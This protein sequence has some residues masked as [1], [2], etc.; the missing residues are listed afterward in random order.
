MKKHEKIKV[1]AQEKIDDA[2]P[3]PDELADAIIDDLLATVKTNGRIINR[4]ILKDSILHGFTKLELATVADDDDTEA[5]EQGAPVDP[6]VAREDILNAISNSIFESFEILNIP[7][8]PLAAT[9]ATNAALAAAET[10][11]KYFIR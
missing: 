3:T 6:V 5:N 2:L 9:V 7:K 8:K 10:F 4:R 1:D 11:G